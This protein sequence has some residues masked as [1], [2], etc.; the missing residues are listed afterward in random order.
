MEAKKLIVLAVLLVVIGIAIYR[1]L[2]MDWL[3]KRSSRPVKKP[4]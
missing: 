4:I 1:G 3:K 2:L